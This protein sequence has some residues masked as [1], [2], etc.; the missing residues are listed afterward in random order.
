MY[1]RQHDRGGFPIGLGHDPDHD[2]VGDH[3]SRQHT[4]A[5]QQGQL[6]LQCVLL[7]DIAPIAMQMTG[8]QKDAFGSVSFQGGGGSIGDNHLAKLKTRRG[9][10][11]A[12]SGMRHENSPKGKPDQ[13]KAAGRWIDEK[14]SRQQIGDIRRPRDG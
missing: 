5:Q 2:V 4:Q 7:G 3:A 9:T 11:G 10:L 14:S 12:G 1:I 6:V 13:P 8:E